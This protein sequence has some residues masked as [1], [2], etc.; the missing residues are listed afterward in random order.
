MSELVVETN[1]AA[2]VQIETIHPQLLAA[3]LHHGLGPDLV[4]VSHSLERG[5]GSR[6]SQE[7]GTT[8]PH[9]ELEIAFPAVSVVS[10]CSS[11]QSSPLHF[12]ALSLNLCSSMLQVCG[13]AELSLVK[14][15]RLDKEY[16]SNC[17]T[18]LHY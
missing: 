8:G 5:T 10:P 16:V 4:T 12:P 1:S 18:G 13:F 6:Q 2:V 3:S 15:S 9:Q 7:P 11:G 14:F 17:W